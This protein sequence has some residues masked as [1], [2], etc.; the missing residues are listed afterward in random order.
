MISRAGVLMELLMAQPS[1]TCPFRLFKLL[2]DRGLADTLGDEPDCIKGEFSK[3]FTREN[4]LNS[5]DAY[6]RLREP[7][8]HQP[9]TGAEARASNAHPL[10]GANIG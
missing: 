2:G 4:D 5:E 8:R 6:Q 3:A 9:Q 10:T 1:T 7:P